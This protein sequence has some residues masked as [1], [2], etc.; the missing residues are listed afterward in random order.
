MPLWRGPLSWITSARYALHR[1]VI[2]QG[3]VTALSTDESEPY[4]HSR[5]HGSQ[6]GAWASRQ[7][8]VLSSRRELDE[9]YETLERRWPEGVTVPMPEFWGRGLATEAALPAIDYGFRQLGL[10]QIIGLVDPDNV[11]SVRVLEKL[12]LRFVSIMDYR[13][14]KVARY[15]ID[16]IP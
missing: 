10:K 11:A 6:L 7:S 14:L 12:G 2:V 9:R 16:R 8:S 4:F 13:S 1:Q 15:V 5:P 3:A